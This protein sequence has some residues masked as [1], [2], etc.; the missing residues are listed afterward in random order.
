MADETSVQASNT[1]DNT[2]PNIESIDATI[3]Q[4]ERDSVI[5]LRDVSK[6]EAKQEINALLL[7]SPTPLDYGH[8]LEKLGLDLQLIVQI[9]EELIEEGI[10]EFT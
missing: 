2:L 6:E 1:A 10:I 8:I 4:T 5:V 7:S 3:D 9:C